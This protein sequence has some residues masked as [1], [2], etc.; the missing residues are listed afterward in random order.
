[1][2]GVEVVGFF[3]AEGLQ[4][5]DRE[6]RIGWLDTDEKGLVFASELGKTGEGGFEIIS[7]GGSESRPIRAE[8][9]VADRGG[10][11]NGKS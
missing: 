7:I 2:G 4:I 5:V 8:K 1:M 6:G 10:L 3:E 11:K 9:I